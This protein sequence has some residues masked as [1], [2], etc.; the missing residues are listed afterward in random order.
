MFTNKKVGLKML[1]SAE[2]HINGMGMSG[3][4]EWHKFQ[5]PSTFQS[6]V[7]RVERN[8]T[9]TPDYS[10][11]MLLSTMSVTW[12]YWNCFSSNVFNLVAFSI[13]KPWFV[14]APKNEVGGAC[15]VLVHKCSVGGVTL[16]SCLC[17]L[18]LHTAILL[19]QCA[20]MVL[21]LQGRHCFYNHKFLCWLK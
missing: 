4:V 16:V 12:F 20:K 18:V 11:W 21:L 19:A 6:G 8:L 3:G 5:L 9:K 1:I 15:L 2:Q 14:A 13:C 17:E 10:P 7:R